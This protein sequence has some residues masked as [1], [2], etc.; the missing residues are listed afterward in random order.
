M[1]Q[2]KMSKTISEQYREASQHLSHRTAAEPQPAEEDIRLTHGA[3][4][5]ANPIAAASVP[6]VRGGANMYGA[7]SIQKF[8]TG[9]G[10]LSYTHEDADGW[11]N[12]VAKF[13]PLN[14]RF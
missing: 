5:E 4:E 13:V 12:Y 7:N 9:D 10:N 1:E 14:F 6:G 2:H 3:I 8:A 11:A